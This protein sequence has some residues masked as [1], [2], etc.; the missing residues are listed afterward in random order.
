MENTEINYVDIYIYFI[1]YLHKQKMEAGAHTGCLSNGPDKCW[2]KPLLGDLGQK[3]YWAEV[4]ILQYFF[5]S[6]KN[7][8]NKGGMTTKAFKL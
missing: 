4:S 7:K 3:V 8:N 2:I 5:K 6:K 1:I